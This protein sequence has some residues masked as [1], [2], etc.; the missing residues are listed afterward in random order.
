MLKLAY[1]R[2]FAP[3]TRETPAGPEGI[4][5]DKVR[6]AMRAA[7]MDCAFEPMNLPE[8][9]PA[10][11]SGAVDAIAATGAAPERAEI[12]SYSDPLLIT[13]GAWYVLEGTDWPSDAG[14]ERPRRD[15]PRA[16]TPGH[17]P[18]FEMMGARFPGL[19]IDAVA[20]YAEALED[21]VNGRAI[22]AGLNKQV[23]EIMAQ[24]DHPGRFSLP[25]R[26][27]YE[28]ALA[29]AVPAGDPKGLLG[30]FNAAL[31]RLPA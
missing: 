20:D 22:A 7:G 28:V 13:G 21:V 19:S 2:D 11:S 29:L 31:A 26:L 30:R 4:A 6:A 9:I 18:L 16:V 27:F 12:L 17:G 1:M 10:L 5:I 8:M 3:F 15:P 23:G 14:L 24:R 25:A